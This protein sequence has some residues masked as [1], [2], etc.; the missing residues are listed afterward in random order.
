MPCAEQIFLHT[1]TKPRFYELNHK[2]TF[3]I[4]PVAEKL[5]GIHHI[6]AYSIID[7]QEFRKSGVR[8]MSTAK[9]QN[10]KYAIL[11]VHTNEEK[12]LFNEMVKAYMAKQLKTSTVTVTSP[13]WTDFASTW[14]QGADG[15]KLFY[16]IPSY[17]D[18][19]FRKW[20]QT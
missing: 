10:A 18:A 19:H 11:P 5:R 15:I 3:L 20:K 12:R 1:W 13:H 6:E 8:M 7:A 14:N 16:K 2:E 9:L 17:L 4:S